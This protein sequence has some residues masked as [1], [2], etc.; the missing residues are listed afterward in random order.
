MPTYVLVGG[1]A[2]LAPDLI[3]HFAK[4]PTNEVIV[5]YRKLKTEICGTYG[6]NVRQVCVGD[7]LNPDNVAVLTNQCTNGIDCLVSLLGSVENA[8]LEDMSP[9]Q[10]FAAINN[11]LTVNFNVLHA[12]IPRMNNPSN[13]VVV[14]SV[15]GRTGG[16]GCANYAAAKAGLQGLVKAASNELIPKG[17]RINLLELGYIEAGM[18]LTINPDIRNKITKLIPMRAFGSPTDFIEAV[19]YLSKVRYMTGSVLSLTGGL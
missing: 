2:G 13:V 1:G 5:S 15:I 9:A 12:C 18:G 3:R 16:Y 10:W 19:Q 8:K 11:N 17:V 4:D 6:D 7:L 14:G